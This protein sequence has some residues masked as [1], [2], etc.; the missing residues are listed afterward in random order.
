MWIAVYA[1]EQLDLSSET[2]PASVPPR[3]S[4]HPLMTHQLFGDDEVI[5]GY[6]NLKVSLNG[7][8]S[9]VICP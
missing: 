8:P 3:A 4:F 2:M 1:A 6:K 7:F 9:L 5:K